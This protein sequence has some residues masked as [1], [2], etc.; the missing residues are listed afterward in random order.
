MTGKRVARLERS[1]RET[2]VTV[3]LDI[4]G[5]GR[6]DVSTDTQFLT[7]MVETLA[8][9]ASFD[10]VMTATGDNPHHLAEDAAITLGQ[11]FREAVGTA[12]VTRMASAVLPMDDALVMVSLDIVDRPYADVDCPDP[13]YHHFFRSFAMAAGLTLHIMEIRGFDE[14]HIVEASF[15]AM[16]AALK[17]AVAP[18]AE[19]LST[20]DSVRVV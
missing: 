9:Y 7:H 12:P 18:R 8:R 1:T 11:A 5:E 16:G 4:D 13:L 2:A 17:Q 19:E 3:D 10:I 6:F 15:K 14:H 20:K